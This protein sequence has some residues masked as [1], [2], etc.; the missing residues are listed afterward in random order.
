MNQVPA[1]PRGGH[2]A[3]W[4][5]DAD[6][7]AAA[8]DHMAALKHA[9]AEHLRDNL[10]KLTLEHNVSFAE[11]AR[12]IGRSNGNCFYNLMHRRSNDLSHAT[13][14]RVC[15]A[16]GITLDELTGRRADYVMP[17]PPAA[18][19][20]AAGRVQDAVA[21]LGELAQA[22]AAARDATARA[23]RALRVAARLLPR[24]DPSAAR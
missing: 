17:A 1:R 5:Q 4:A 8:S 12:R 16:F 23:G 21:A 20:E 14:R 24:P 11:L 6:A 3:A 2:R 22:L 19:V 9:R 15:D 13:L 18:Q 10:R 7:A